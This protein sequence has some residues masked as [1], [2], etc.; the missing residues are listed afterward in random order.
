[1]KKA[2]A[3][4]HKRSDFQKYKMLSNIKFILSIIAGI[5]VF[6]GA[7]NAIV[8]KTSTDN[9]ISDFDAASSLEKMETPYGILDGSLFRLSSTRMSAVTVSVIQSLS[10][11]LK[12]SGLRRRYSYLSSPCQ[13]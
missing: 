11:L 13:G 8:Y 10:H 3:T 1:M 5:A 9:L 12:G 7:Y 4:G 6:F 2:K